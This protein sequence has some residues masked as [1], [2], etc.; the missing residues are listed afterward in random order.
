MQ[1]ISEKEL[2]GIPLN[3]TE[4][5]TMKTIGRVLSNLEGFGTAGGRAELV[6]DVH[7]DTING[8]VLQEATGKPMLILVAVPDENGI[9]FLARGAM[10]SYYEFAQP[11]SDRLTDEQWWGMIEDDS[12][13]PM[14][15]WVSSF[16]LGG[17]VSNRGM[18]FNYTQEFTMDWVAPCVTIIGIIVKKWRFS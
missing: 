3:E 13:P 18:E 1:I 17:E 2:Q 5:Y 14:P 10:Y 16:V 9:P 11:M 4:Y 12:L 7:T 6:V 8:K 15:W